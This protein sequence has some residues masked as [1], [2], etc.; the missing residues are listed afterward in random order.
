MATEIHDQIKGEI[1]DLIRG[2]IGICTLIDDKD[3]KKFL[4][5]I[6]IKRIE[7][8]GECCSP[9]KAER[10]AH[11]IT[12]ATHRHKIHLT[13]PADFKI[14][15]LYIDFEEGVKYSKPRTSET[16][17]G[18][19]IFKH[20]GGIVDEIIGA[21]D[22]FLGA[23]ATG[24]ETSS[25]AAASGNEETRKFV[26]AIDVF[27]KLGDFSVQKDQNTCTCVVT[28]KTT[29]PYRE[30]RSGGGRDDTVQ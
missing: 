7:S 9:T 10:E 16:T 20:V 8:D 15:L 30:S 26:K 13:A 24:A 12:D 11:T 2:A 18:S 14:R 29:C 22:S 5:N 27:K 17:I 4:D 3:F 21:V 1:K 19:V 6:K 23:D 25:E 28:A